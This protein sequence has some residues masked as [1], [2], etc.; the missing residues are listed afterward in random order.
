MIDIALRIEGLSK[1]YGSTLPLDGLDLEVAQGEVFGFLGPN[2]AGKTTA[3]KISL[4]LVHPTAG[5]VQMLGRPSRDWRVRRRV[6][7]LPE[8]FRFQEWLTAR[9]FLDVHGRLFGVAAVERRRRADD[10]LER[11]DLSRQAD[12]QLRDYSKGMLQRVGLAQALIHRPQLVFLD[13]PTSGLDPLGRRLVRDVIQELRLEGTTVFLNS[14]LLS[15]IEVTCDRV[16]FVRRGRLV[17]C[18]PLHELLAAAM[19]VEVLLDPGT[20]LSES[21]LASLPH[22]AEMAG[23]RLIVQLPDESLVPDLVERLVALGAR[24]RAVKP[25]RSSLEEVFMQ[26][27]EGEEAG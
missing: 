27:M 26:L 19:E 16:G 2:G 14:H 21:A 9:E 17:H 6:G 3:V 20:K 13:E 5:E 11:L 1:Q 24:I 8:H 25:R 18:G 23:D 12:R 22:E 10:L 15:E 7:F 4:D